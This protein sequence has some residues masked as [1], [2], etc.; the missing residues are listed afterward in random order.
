MK[1]KA[2][3]ITDKCP[4]CGVE[5]ICNMTE[6][7]GKFAGKL[8]WQ[9]KSGGAHYNFDAATKDISCN[10]PSEE[11]DDDSQQIIEEYEA[12]HRNEGMNSNDI[13]NVDK[14]EMAKV[15]ADPINY[16]IIMKEIELLDIIEDVVSRHLPKAEPAHIGMYV[17]EI[18]RTINSR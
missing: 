6:G 14:I 4:S 15:K 11:L 12:D 5:V 2:E 8:Q 10:K 1:P 9:N 18:Y 7:K 16:K 17:K 13:T 3:G